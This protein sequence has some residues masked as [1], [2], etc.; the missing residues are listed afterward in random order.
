[1]TGGYRATAVALVA[2]LALGA[3]GCAADDPVGSFDDTA[4]EDAAAKALV[5]LGEIALDECH[6]ADGTYA[7]CDAPDGQ[8][9]SGWSG[10]SATGYTITERSDSGATFRSVRRD[11]TITRTCAP[12]GK[13]GCPADGT[14]KIAG[15]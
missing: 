9:V 11:G 13:G 8:K 14:W 1:M 6:R 12:A 3:G 10:L 2:G 7:G 15:R 4:T 5:G